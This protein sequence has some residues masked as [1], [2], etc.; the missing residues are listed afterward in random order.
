MTGNYLVTS[1]SRLKSAA[2]GRLYPT[3]EDALRSANDILGKGADSVW[4]VDSEGNL[5]LPED[6]VRLR[7][8]PSLSSPRRPV[9]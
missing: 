5:M 4:I 3:I 2:S 1:V 7:L 8:S 6:Q 9:A